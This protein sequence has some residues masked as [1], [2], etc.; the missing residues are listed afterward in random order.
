MYSLKFKEWCFWEGTVTGRATSGMLVKIQC[1]DMDVGH[2]CTL[3]LCTFL[4][5]R[6]T[7]KKVKKKCACRCGIVT[8]KAEEF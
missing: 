8:G 5:I 2:I 1:L 7:L 6:Y 4:R 3:I